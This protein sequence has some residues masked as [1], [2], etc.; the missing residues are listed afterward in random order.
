MEYLRI[1]KLAEQPIYKQIIDSVFMAI[2]ADILQPGDK[3]PSLNEIKEKFDLSRDTVLTAFTEMKNR[4]VISSAPGK[5]YYV[6][7]NNVH[8]KEKVFLLFDEFNTFK[9]DIYNSFKESIGNKAVVDIY[10]H[11]FNAKVFRTLISQNLYDYTSYVIMPG[12][13]Q[14]IASDINQLPK[15]KTYIL[16]RIIPSKNQ[17]GAIYQDFELDMK[18]AMESGLDLLRKYNQLI[19]VSPP[20]KEPVERIKG[21]KEF[22]NQ[23]DFIG[24]ASDK[25]ETAHI[26]KGNVFFVPNDRHLVYLIKA[27]EEKQLTLG[28]DFGLVSFNDTMLKEV[29]AGGITTIST[30]FKQMGKSLAQMVL[31]GERRQLKNPSKLIIRKSL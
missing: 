8:Q 25:I 24:V 11:H 18:S 29:V 13:I 7:T 6:S 3:I 31:K 4:G 1:D 5:G 23:H 19:L 27:A 15:E 10:F 14:N 2:R 22:C 28:D 21:F 30:D 16:D 20:G 12:S 17:W 9:E 26:V